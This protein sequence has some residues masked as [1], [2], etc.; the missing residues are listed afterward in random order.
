MPTRP[1]RFVSSVGFRVAVIAMLGFMGCVHAPA[2]LPS[3]K[4]LGR[5]YPLDEATLKRRVAEWFLQ[6]HVVLLPSRDPH[7]LRSRPRESDVGTFVERDVWE[8]HFTPKG[9][10]RTEVLILRAHTSEWLAS[11]DR[12]RIIGADVLGEAQSNG[13]PPALETRDTPAERELA[14]YLDFSA[15]VEVVGREALNSSTE[16]PTLR[17]TALTPPTAPACEVGPALELAPGQV[18]L[19]SDPTGT[20]EAPAQLARVVCHALA[21]GVSLTLALSIPV[22]EQVRINRW[23]DSRG[24]AEDRAE[25]L[26]GPFWTRLWQDGRSS[27]SMFGLLENVRSWGAQGH[28]LTVLAADLDE[29]GNARAAFI[30]ARLLRHLR[31]HPDRALLGFFSNT[32]ASKSEAAAWDPDFLPVGY[33]LAAA[34]QAVRSFDVAY[35]LGFQWVCKLSRGGSL[36]CGTWNIA[37]GP[38][39]QGTFDVTGVKEFPS[40][41]PEGHDGLWFVGRLTASVPATGSYKDEGNHLGSQLTV[42]IDGVSKMPL[43]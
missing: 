30:A 9:P 21:Q 37:P 42:P 29:R 14:E 13:D 38:K 43:W 34:G 23:L 16:E 1:T 40:T 7:V 19:L 10:R 17:Q 39:Q 28:D 15:A 4:P 25:L 36:R 33:R 20:T 32:L 26:R 41:S 6:R 11:S 27:Q 3:S 24:T 5:A 18:V 12:S 31:E 8:L 22:E 2:A 35:N